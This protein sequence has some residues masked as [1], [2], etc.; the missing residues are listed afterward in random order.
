MQEFKSLVSSAGVAALHV[1]TGSR[2][3]P[4]PKDFVGKGKAK[5]IVEAVKTSSA[6]VVLCDYALSPA[7]KRNLE[8]LRECRVIDFTGLILD[9]FSQRAHP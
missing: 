7:Q 9:I 1:I 2:K 4:H 8:C 6:S 5:E 3:V